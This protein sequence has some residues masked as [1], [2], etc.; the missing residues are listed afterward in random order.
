VVRAD[1]A[2]DKLAAADRG[3]AVAARDAEAVA[4]H[5]AADRLISANRAGVVACGD[6]TRVS[7]GEAA[8]TPTGSMD[9]AGAAACIDTAIVVA[10]QAA[11][12]VIAADRSGAV[13][14]DD[15]PGVVVSHQAANIAI[16]V[17]GPGATCSD[18]AP[19]VVSHKTAG[20]G[21]PADRGGAVAG[22][23]ASTVASCETPDGPLSADE[24]SGITC[25]DAAPVQTHQPADATTSS[26]DLHR[27]QTQIGNLRPRSQLPKQAQVPQTCDR[28]MRDCVAMAVETTREGSSLIVALHVVGVRCNDGP[29]E[30][31][32]AGEVGVEVDLGGQEEVLVVITGRLAEGDQVGGRGDL[33][34]VLSRSAAAGVLG[35]SDYSEREYGH[36][37]QRSSHGLDTSQQQDAMVSSTL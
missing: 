24:A 31:L 30:D 23:D 20:A 34:R 4:A 37:Y 11:D 5:K 28:K 27:F 18:G 14:V 32:P 8:D 25:G 26:V 2:T 22:S 17:D 36:Y 12:A 10:D 13:G 7:T 21:T 29:V 19:V 15:A 3:S 6:V 1:E 9:V 16:S 35:L 33:V